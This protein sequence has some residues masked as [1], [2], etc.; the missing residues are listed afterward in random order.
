MP[1]VQPDAVSYLIFGEPR[2]VTPVTP[3]RRP[4]QRI[5]RRC[6]DWLTMPRSVCRSS[7]A[8]VVRTRI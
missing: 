1:A 6:W 7:M 5:M 8:S 2:L 4:T 3:C